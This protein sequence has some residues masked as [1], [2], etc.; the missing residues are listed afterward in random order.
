MMLL[1]TLGVLASTNPARSARQDH[2]FHGKH[3]TQGGGATTRILILSGN[4]ELRTYDTAGHLVGDVTLVTFYTPITGMC[5]D[6]EQ[7]IYATTFGSSVYEFPIGST[8]PTRT[9]DTL[10][11]VMDDPYT[12]AVD[13]ITGD[14]EVGGG[15]EG[16]GQGFGLE[17]FFPGQKEPYE[18]GG[19]PRGSSLSAV[20]FDRS[21][22]VWIDG[23]VNQSVVVG[24]GNNF[25]SLPFFPQGFQSG[26][27]ALHFDRANNLVVAN[28]Y[29]GSL[30]VYPY[31]RVNLGCTTLR[32]CLISLP[33]VQS[34]GQFAFAPYDK[35]VFV[36]DGATGYTS[37]YSYPQ[38]GQ[39]VVTINFSGVGMAVINQT[40][41]AQPTR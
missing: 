24:N 21:G 35:M 22:S 25:Q 36:V 17:L 39:P 11:G 41:V 4:G 6:G 14:V 29:T 33:G 26:A 28:P 2:L 5:S 3:S 15:L 8:S 12:C 19:G 38:V 7:N 13:P 32:K 18:V 31:G 10:S 1:A 30:Q 16:F 23:N 34:P 20:T 37:G 40:A 9:L 27:G